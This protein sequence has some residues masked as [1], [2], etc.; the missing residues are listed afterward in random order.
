MPFG[1]GDDVDAVHLHAAGPA[2]VAAAAL[3]ITRTGAGAWP[4]LRAGYA[5]HVDPSM[6]GAQVAA[7]AV[8]LGRYLM[9]A[10]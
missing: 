8:V 4:T 5:G 7:A 2:L 3:R 10:A 6:F 1:V 9:I